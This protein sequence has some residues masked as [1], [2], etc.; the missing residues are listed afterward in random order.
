[1]FNGRPWAACALLL[2]GTG[3]C[4]R[5]ESILSATPVGLGPSGVALTPKRPLHAKGP[6]TRVCLT[7]GERALHVRPED[8]SLEVQGRGIAHVRVYLWTPAG[9]KDSLF[10]RP[11]WF[12]YTD[13][14][15]QRHSS[16]VAAGPATMDEPRQGMVCLWE[17]VPVDAERYYARVEIVSD[18]EIPVRQVTFWSGRLFA[19]P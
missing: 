4:G 13:S 17:R 16:P 10:R 14:S 19:A 3:A 15:G 9:K 1:M 12:N 8:G 2:V 18:V 5:G 6:D 11:S 7:A